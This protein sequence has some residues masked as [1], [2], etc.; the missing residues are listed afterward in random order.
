LLDY[1]N[2]T[3]EIRRVDG[4]A[5]GGAYCGRRLAGL[6]PEYGFTVLVEGSSDWD[7]TPLLG[8]YRDDDA[9]CLTALL[10]MVLAEGQ[11]S[12][13]FRPEG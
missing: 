5:T 8:R 1:Y 7:M 4:Q 11:K 2:H 3:M 9:V 6:L 10:G 13:Q 12:G